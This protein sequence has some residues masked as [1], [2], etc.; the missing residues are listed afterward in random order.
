[1]A[2]SAPEAKSE[3]LARISSEDEDIFHIEV[4]PDNTMSQGSMRLS[5]EEK[6]ARK[7]ASRGENRKLHHHTVTV[8]AEVDVTVAG[9]QFFFSGPLGS[10][11]VDLLK[12]DSKGFAAFKVVRDDAGKVT[13]VMIAGPC[14]DTTRSCKTHLENCVNGVVRGYL[15]YMQLAGVGYRVSKTSKD[16]TFNTGGAPAG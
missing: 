16:V 4:G 14:K 8:P 1:M 9:T 11:A 2:T 7:R 3:G 5:R 13:D 12:V 6:K 10:N 15:M